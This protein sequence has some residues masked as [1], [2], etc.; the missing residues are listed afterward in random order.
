MIDADL[1][2]QLNP[3]DKKYRRTAV[4]LRAEGDEESTGPA[5]RCVCVSA[6]VHAYLQAFA[7]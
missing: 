5:G 6:T 3:I 2:M 7:V 1:R 4:A